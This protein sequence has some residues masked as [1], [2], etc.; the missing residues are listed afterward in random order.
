MRCFRHDNERDPAYLTRTCTTLQQAASHG[1]RHMDSAE[2]LATGPA[3]ACAKVNL[4]R[5]PDGI[6]QNAIC[7]S[8]D[9]S[10]R[11][12]WLY[13]TRARYPRSSAWSHE[14]WKHQYRRHCPA[15]QRQSLANGRYMHGTWCITVIVSGSLFARSNATATSPPRSFGPTHILHFLCWFSTFRAD[16][17]ACNRRPSTLCS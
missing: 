6:F 11:A 13:S 2:R 8:R 7:L 9:S 4:R 14:R 10:G 15:W 12:A 17:S 3:A 16:L 1:L 5:D